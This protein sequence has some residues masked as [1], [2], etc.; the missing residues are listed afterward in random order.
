[1]DWLRLIVFLKKHVYYTKLLAQE[2]GKLGKEITRMATVKNN[3]RFNLYRTS[4]LFDQCLR[5]CE[6]ILKNLSTAEIGYYNSLED[7]LGVGSIF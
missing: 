3:S 6:V 5:E 2:T 1:M 7:T 4:V